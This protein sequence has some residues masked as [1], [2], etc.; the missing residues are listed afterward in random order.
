MV[1]L[2]FFLTGGFT[3]AGTGGVIWGLKVNIVDVD[4]DGEDLQGEDGADT[5]VKGNGFPDTRFIS[6]VTDDDIGIPPPPE[7]LPFFRVH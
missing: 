5:D 4:D 2:G 7:D 1:T 6:D 3:F